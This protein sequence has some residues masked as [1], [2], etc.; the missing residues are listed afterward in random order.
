MR[1]FVLEPEA[2]DHTLLESGIHDRNAWAK[3]TLKGISKLVTSD[4]VR[5]RSYGPYWWPIKRMLANTGLS[6]ETLEAK[7]NRYLYLEENHNLAAGVLMAMEWT[8]L[9]YGANEYR[10]LQNDCESSYVLEDPEMESR[11]LNL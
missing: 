5:Y 1:Y 6:F 3:R 10:L 7:T 9:Y 2:L 8:A 11:V 4:P